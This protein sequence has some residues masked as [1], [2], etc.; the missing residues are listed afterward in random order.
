MSANRSL[1]L[2]GALALCT[3]AGAQAP[4]T[5][6]VVEKL[7]D[8]AAAVSPELGEARA[9]I[10]ADRA[11]V[12]QV[13]ALPDPVLSLGIQNDG[14][15]R[16]AIGAAETSW[17]SIMLT[18]PL[19]WPGK[20][21]LREQ[22]AELDVRAARARQQRAL[23]QLDARVRRAYLDLLL[24]RGQ[25]DLL[26]EL[27]ALWAGA[28]R[29]A[30][31]RYEAGRVPQSDLLRAQLEL[32]RL[33]QRR[34]A[35][36][37]AIASRLAEV[38]RLRAR[39]LDEEVATR[40]RLFDVADPAIPPAEQAQADAESRSPELLL[41][42][43][44]VEQW[45]RR[46]EL[47]R[48]ETRPDFAVS[49]GVMPRGLLEPM[50]TVGFSIGLPLWTARKQ[51]Q[52]VTESEQRGIAQA[53]GAEAVR[54]IL[55]LRTHERLQALKALARTNRRFRD[56]L[57]VLS[58]ATARSALAQ[59]EVG[60]LPFASVLDALSGSVADRGSYLASIADAQRLAIAQREV[61]L[62]ATPAPSV[63]LPGGS[64]P[65]GGGVANRPGPASA[66]GTAA[67]NSSR[68]GGM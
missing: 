7:L 62:E 68:M 12:P 46:V 45:G 22:V 9:S 2:G 17:V 24:A 51:G 18:Q 41:A 40:T 25:L 44:A 42:R 1:A 21:A 23:L 48:K 8:E 38:N 26:A 29:L 32:A 4:A 31:A 27:E 34:W 50:W 6:A 16:I 60:Q 28:E 14:F 57:L 56:G 59:Y 52:A 47:A 64:M 53:Q 5:D 65:G 15:T 43:L 49:A 20:R 19:P 13:E 61:S 11:R 63:G 36:E 37:A 3:A 30:R 35:L 58:Q 54:Q 55:R 39:P 66:P 33:G 67:E 10:E